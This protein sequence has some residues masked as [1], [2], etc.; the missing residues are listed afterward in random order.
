MKYL[1]VILSILFGASIISIFFLWPK[2][3]P[4]SSDALVT[5]N[6]KPLT[7]EIIQEYKA[8]DTH[9]GEDNDF[10]NEIITKQLLIDEAQRLGIDKEPSFRLSLKTFYEHSLIKLLMERIEKDISIN[11]TEQEIDNY[12][13]SF[14]RT[15]TFYMLKTSQ[16][17]DANTIRTDGTKHSELFDNL[18]ENLR[19]VL[20]SLNPGEKTI[21]FITGNEKLAIFLEKINGKTT[22]SKIDRESVR[23]N[24]KQAKVETEINS[25]I[26]NL[27]QNASITY[28][29]IQ[30]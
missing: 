14:G 24:L 21:S 17:V 4:V 15:F 19:R 10:I 16:D 13:A 30:E 26:E 5:I 8:K 27:R 18:G 7:R 12:L 11:V 1:F 25:W 6:G 20:F 9:H 2:Q 29:S 23:K 3:Q 28:H 22:D